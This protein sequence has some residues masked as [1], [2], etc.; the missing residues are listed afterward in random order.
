MPAKRYRPHGR[1]GAFQM[2]QSNRFVKFRHEMA[3]QAPL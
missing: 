1:N 3:E 2:V